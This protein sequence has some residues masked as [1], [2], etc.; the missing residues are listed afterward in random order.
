[1]LAVALKSGPGRDNAREEYDNAVAEP[2]AHQPTKTRAINYTSF[3]E[4]Y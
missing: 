2:L 1:M 3:V 4:N